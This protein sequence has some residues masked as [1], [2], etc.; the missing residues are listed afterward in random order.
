MTV[1]LSVS[2]ARQ[3]TVCLALISIF[4]ATQ[5]LPAEAARKSTSW[6][7]VP[8]FYA[9]TRARIQKKDGYGEYRNLVRDGQGIEYGI[10]TVRIEAP[11]SRARPNHRRPRER[12]ARAGPPASRPRA[13]PSSLRWRRREAQQTAAPSKSSAPKSDW[14]PAHQYSSRRLDPRASCRGLRVGALARGD[15]DDLFELDRR[16]GAVDRRRARRLRVHG[17]RAPARRAARADG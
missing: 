14:V 1:L 7:S 8:V 10:V 6:L 2:R 4:L 13:F 16:R 5:L 9:T 11:S 15:D 3:L 17:D 12:R